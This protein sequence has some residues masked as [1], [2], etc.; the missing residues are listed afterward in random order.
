[1][2]IKLA[3]NFDEFLFNIFTEKNMSYDVLEYVI[4]R[5]TGG[6]NLF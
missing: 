5:Y 1:M 6:G 2:S 3:D 4:K